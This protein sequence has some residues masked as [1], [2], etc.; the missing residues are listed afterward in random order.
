MTPE[1]AILV[2]IGI[3]LVGALAIS[4]AGRISPNL[5]EA[6]TAIT[7]LPLIWVVW[8]LLPILMDGGRPSVEVS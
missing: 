2:A 3:P 7:S 5:R 8:G 1:T 4:L 6:A